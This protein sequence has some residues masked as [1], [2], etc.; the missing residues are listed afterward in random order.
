[1]DVPEEFKQIL[2]EKAKSISDYIYLF[3]HDLDC[4]KT[5]RESMLY[6]LMAGGKRIRPILC[7]TWAELVGLE[8][9]L[10]MNFACGLELIHTYSL[11]HDDLPAMDDDDLRRGKPTNHKVFGEDIAIL[12]GDA[13][14]T[15]GF[16]LMLSTPI[17]PDYLVQA[18]LCITTAI[19]PRGMIGGQVL[20]LSLEN[21]TCV[22]LKDVQEMHLL[23][24]GK[25]IEAA[26]ESGVLLAGGM[27]ATS[28]DSHHARAYG[29]NIGLAFQIVDDIL[30]V[31]GKEQELG[32]PVGSDERQG[33]STY[34]KLIGLKQSYQLA[35]S[36]ID[37]AIEA[38]NSYPPSSNK[39]FLINLAKYIVQRIS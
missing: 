19:G 12:A 3:L 11:I 22:Q 10:A 29:Q 17:K 38:L 20:D 34:P 26:C 24:T 8:S 18:V 1:M 37:K 32:K 27:G 15:H 6:S 9:S 25:F 7:L 39:E 2:Q 30:D 5:L 35:N 23:K 16:E 33:K 31:V 13:L 36:C 28:Y 14:L 21:K 4:P